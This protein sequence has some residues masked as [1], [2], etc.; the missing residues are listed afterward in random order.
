MTESDFQWWPRVTK[1]A[2]DA[3][4]ADAAAV[5]D[6]TRGYASLVFQHP[7]LLLIVFFWQRNSFHTIPEDEIRNHEL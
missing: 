2:S 1:N 7:D 4:N 3:L 6:A 5:I